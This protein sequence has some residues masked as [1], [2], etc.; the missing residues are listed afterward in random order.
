MPRA[1]GLSDS[2]RRR[3]GPEPILPADGR[4]AGAEDGFRQLVDSAD[5]E[6]LARPD[7]D[8]HLFVSAT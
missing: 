6:I 3:E 2:E 4:A 1:G 7:V 8:G 5:I